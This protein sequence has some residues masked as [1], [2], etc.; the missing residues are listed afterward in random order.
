MSEHVVKVTY[1]EELVRSAAGRYW[2]RAIG[3]TGLIALGVVALWCVVM[4]Y[5]RVDS[6]MVSF[7]AGVW[8]ICVVIVAAAYFTIRNRALNLYRRMDAKAATFTFSET[9]IGIEA[10]SGKSEMPWKTIDG[11]VQYPDLWLFSIAKSSYF[12]L[13]IASV[14]PETRE[15]ILA[16]CSETK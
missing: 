3:N 6:W 8:V 15:Y 7:F 16:H 9:G 11:V 13:P 1:S 4:V 14:P 2:K 10:D 5:L 12:T